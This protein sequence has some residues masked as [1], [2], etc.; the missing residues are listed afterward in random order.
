VSSRLFQRVREELGLAYA[1]FSAT[2]YFSDAGV[3]SV[4]A[5]AEERNLPRVME[6]VYQEIGDL[7]RHP[8]PKAEVERA[9]NRLSNAFLLNLDDPSGRMVRLGTVASLGRKP[10]SPEEVLQRF[11]AVTPE[12]VQELAKKFLRPEKAAVAAVGPSA[13]RIRKALRKVVEV[14]V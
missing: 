7:S 4:Y 8:L 14:K 1:V 6:V 13:E 10:I 9:I 12:A 5:A 2:A 3:L 11:A